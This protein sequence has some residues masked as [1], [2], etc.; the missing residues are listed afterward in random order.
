MRP[1]QNRCS[2]KQQQE[3]ADV[4][5]REY[6]NLNKLW[7][8]QD[9]RTVKARLSWQESERIITERLKLEAAN[10]DN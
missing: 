10:D 6:T 7:G 9:L 1:I 3:N 4:R 8:S 2:L 5:F